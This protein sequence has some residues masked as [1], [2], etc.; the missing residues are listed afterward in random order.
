MFRLRAA[1][2]SDAQFVFDLSND[3]AVR[4]NSTHSAP[5][6][7]DEH[8]A[9]FDRMLASADAI[10]YVVEKTDGTPVGQIRFQHGKDGWVASMSLAAGLRGKGVASGLCRAAMRR[11]GLR[12]VLAT[13][14]TTNVAALGVLHAN[15]FRDVGTEQVAGVEYRV[16]RFVDDVWVVA[17]MSANHRGDLARAKEIVVAAQEAGANAIK[18]QTYT[19]DT[20]TL[21]CDRPPFIVSGGTLWDGQTLH[22]V[23]RSAMTPWEWVP[24]LKAFADS[25]GIELFSTPFDPSAVDFLEGVGVRHYKIASFEAV[26]LPLVRH[27]AATGKPILVSTGICTLDE[28]QDVV[29]ACHAEGNLDVTLLKCTSSYPA[30]LSAM[31]VATVRDMV[32]RFAPQGVRIGLSDHSLSPVPAVVAVALGARVIEKHLTL[33]RPD[34]DAEASFALLPDEFARTVREVRDAEMA[35]GEVSYSVDETA[36]NYRRSLFVAEDIAKGE[37]FSQRNV[38]SVRPAGGLEP[39]FLP[40]ILGRRAACDIQRG[41]PLVWQMVEKGL[42]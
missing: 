14:Q 17:E 42:T 12:E 33:D 15:G 29:D 6:A 5:I 22:D 30:E 39:K 26:D 31:N 10:F 36:R 11:S 18:L 37:R 27:A 2:P 40:E 38:R 20:M 7:W 4:A 21:D 35:L 23:Y 25:I 32:A 24:E 13:T 34:G 3:A 9:W 28:M 16:L 41:E 8:V 1:R 19:A